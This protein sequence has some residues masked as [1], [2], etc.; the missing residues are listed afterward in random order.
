MD[1]EIS[2]FRPGCGFGQFQHTA[3]RLALITGMVR[4]ALFELKGNH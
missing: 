3:K 2:N 4:K 1:G